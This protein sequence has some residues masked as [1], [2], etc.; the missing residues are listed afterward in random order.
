MGAVG[1]AAPTGSRQWG[2]YYVFA[3]TDICQVMNMFLAFLLKSGNNIK[4]EIDS[5][6]RKNNLKIKKRENRHVH[7]ADKTLLKRFG[8]NTLDMEIQTK[9][10]SG[11]NI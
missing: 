10:T 9:M 1:A 11:E 8:N 7:C 3:P 2:Q 6:S 5:R 4:R